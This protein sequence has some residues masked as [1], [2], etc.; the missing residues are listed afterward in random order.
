MHDYLEHFPNCQ[1]K[2]IPD[3]GH[4]ISVEQPELY[5]KTMRDFLN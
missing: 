3:A 1:L 2:I 4:A 5:L